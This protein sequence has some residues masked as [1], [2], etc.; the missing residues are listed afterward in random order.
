LD[1]HSTSPSLI[2]MADSL[3]AGGTSAAPS[4]VPAAQ[5]ANAVDPEWGSPPSLIE[6]DH[7]SPVVF[8]SHYQKTAQLQCAVLREALMGHGYSCFF[9][10]DCAILN[11]EVMKEGVSESSLYVLFLSKGVLA[12]PFVRL[13][14]QTA[15]D[16]G[17]DV[18]LVLEV[19]PFH[20]GTSLEA[21]MLE[22]ISSAA[23]AAAKTAEKKS[24]AAFDGGAA[25]RE[26][27]DAIVADARRAIAPIAP[28]P[29]AGDAA[30]AA[31]RDLV[32]AAATAIAAASAGTATACTAAAAAAAAA[33]AA[34]SVAAMVRELYIRGGA[35]IMFRR[36]PELYAETLF[37]LEK[38]IL[39]AKGE[40]AASPL[41]LKCLLRRPNLLTAVQSPT[42][43]SAASGDACGDPAC[44]LLHRELSHVLLVGAEEARD[45]ALLLEV[46][47]LER[48]AHPKDRSSIVGEN[49]SDG[50]S[51]PV[52]VLRSMG[53]WRGSG[54]GGAADTPQPPRESTV[55]V[56]TLVGGDVSDAEAARCAAAAAAAAAALASASRALTEVQRLVEAAGSASAGSFSFAAQLLAREGD[57]AV[58]VASANAE[59]RKLVAAAGQ[60]SGTKA[61]EEEGTL[62]AQSARLVV[63]IL[64]KNSFKS[65]YVRGALR[66]AL[67]RTAPIQLIW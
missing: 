67:A 47:A 23:K 42:G 52:E 18:A 43:C 48:V 9:D 62:A 20:G 8:L 37:A 29:T 36:G 4:A 64:T 17:K 34:D 21:V 39:G 7:C 15:L 31:V 57:E 1:T 38:K 13:E 19:D 53:G 44:R 46:A 28:L 10:Q 22:A 60:E 24:K 51:S 56:A 49:M 2:A 55:K 66:S 25:V 32:E 50:G 30:A 26:V 3:S 65:P 12:R 14:A 54:G 16:G 33:V 59:A 11:G 41:T 27:L 45:Q 61:R 6:K 40:K 5:P 58:W 35:P 63:L